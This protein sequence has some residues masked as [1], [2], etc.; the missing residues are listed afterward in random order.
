M[1]DQ[2]S[3]EALAGI[4]TDPESEKKVAQA[5]QLPVD[6][7]KKSATYN[8]TPPMSLAVYE[9]GPGAKNPGR[10]MA[11]YFGSFSNVAAITS[12]DEETDATHIYGPGEAKGGAG[13]WVSWELRMSTKD[14]TKPDGMSKLWLQLKQAYCRAM[15]IDKNA[16]VP[17]AEVLEFPT[18]YA[19]AVRFGTGD[20]DNVA[21]AIT[22][23][24]T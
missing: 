8:S 18:K 7:L 21:Y 2:L 20:E 13:F 3:L 19:L 17:V 11:K 14:P 23:A 24:R 10:K 1:A 22:T 9:A 4:V 6:Y 5:L 16:P 15:G 12:K